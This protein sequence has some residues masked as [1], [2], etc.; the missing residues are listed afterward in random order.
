MMAQ[1]KF[2][3]FEPLTEEELSFAGVIKALYEQRF[4]GA[5]TIHFKDGKA[6]VIDLPAP[7]IKLT[8]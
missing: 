6:S 5:I 3:I 4:T 7:K 1:E 2:V 8:P